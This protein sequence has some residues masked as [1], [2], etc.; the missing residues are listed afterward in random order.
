EYQDTNQAQY[1]LAKRLSQDHPNLCVVGDPDQSIYKWRGANIRNILDFERDFVNARV[2]TLAENFRSTKAILAAADHLINHNIQ[3]K[4]KPLYTGN[5]AGPEE[6][7][8]QFETGLDEADQVVQRIAAAVAQGKRHYRDCA[9][10][11][12]VNAL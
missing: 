6:Q 5:P 11:L 1:E 4:H 7:V 12:R 3:R 9:I 8:L 10:F 2:I